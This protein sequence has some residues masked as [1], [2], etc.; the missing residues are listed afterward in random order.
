M[1]RLKK[2]IEMIAKFFDPKNLG[3]YILAAALVWSIAYTT[4]FNTNKKTIAVNGLAYENVTADKAQLDIKLRRENVNRKESLRRL[5]EDEKKVVDWLINERK[6]TKDEISYGLYGTYPR[7]GK[8]AT[9]ES[10][11]IVAYESTIEIVIKSNDVFKIADVRNMANNFA[12]ENEIIFDNNNASFLYTG[13]EKLK[14]SLLEKAVANA[15]ERAEAL[16]KIRKARVGKM[17]DA[18]QGVFQINPEDDFDVSWGGNFD[19][20]AIYKTVRATVSTTFEIK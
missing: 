15:K 4:R 3:V 12:V 14:I 7:Y 9:E 20:T 10:E 18:G 17:L 19:T 1:L 2:N 6:I 11:Q 13:L 5:K 16:V 8:P